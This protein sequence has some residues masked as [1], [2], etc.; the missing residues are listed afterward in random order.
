M[1]SVYNTLIF[2]SQGEETERRGDV[3]GV[4]GLS[5]SSLGRLTPGNFYRL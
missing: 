4:I 5:E 1:N 3:N 2:M